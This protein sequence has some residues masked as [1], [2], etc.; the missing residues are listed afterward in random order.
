MLS[1][2]RSMTYCLSHCVQVNLWGG[3]LLTVNL[4]T[5]ELFLKTRSPETSV[6]VIMTDDG[7]L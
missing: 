3:A 1:V 2:C 4:D 5:I 6:G 7:R